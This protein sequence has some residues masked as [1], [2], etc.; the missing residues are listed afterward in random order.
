MLWHEDSSLQPHRLLS[1]CG[2]QAPECL[3]SVVCSTGSLVETLGSLV[4]VCGLS[5]LTARGILVPRPGVKHIPPELE[6][7]LLITGPP[8]KSWALLSINHIA[9]KYR[10]MIWTQALWLQNPHYFQYNQWFQTTG[11]QI[12]VDSKG[13][14]LQSVV[15]IS[16]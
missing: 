14:S 9:S 5:C 1:S 11:L 7:R 4:S 8:G 3:G 12:G 16:G 6:G 10:V 2:L 15:G 13:V